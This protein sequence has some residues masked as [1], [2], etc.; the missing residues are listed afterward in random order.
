[1][2]G[3]GTTS[4]DLGPNAHP[5]Q[6]PWPAVVDPLDWELRGL[7]RASTREPLGS[8]WAAR[9]LYASAT[10]EHEVRYGY[11]SA[12]NARPRPFMAGNGK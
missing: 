11:G 12:C 3:P 7:A 4:E 1:M 10:H 8:M 5:R 2:P 9:A 6:G